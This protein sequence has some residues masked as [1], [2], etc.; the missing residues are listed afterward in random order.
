MRREIERDNKMRDSCD[1][2][3][4]KGETLTNYFETSKSSAFFLKYR[5]SIG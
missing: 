1:E 3:R 2:E 4:D 5:E